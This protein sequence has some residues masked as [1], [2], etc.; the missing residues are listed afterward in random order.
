MRESGAD[1]ET[2]NLRRKLL[3]ANF[4]IGSWQD[5]I[6]IQ[7][8]TLRKKAAENDVHG[9]IGI[10]INLIGMAINGGDKLNE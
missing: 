2:L 3:E 9:Q 6:A 1:E 4:G 8:E 5:V 10:L 7:E